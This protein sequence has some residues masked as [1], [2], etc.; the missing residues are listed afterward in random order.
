[1]KVRRID[2]SPDEWIAGCQG[3]S[4]EEEGVYVRLVARIYSRGGPLQLHNLADYCGSDPRRFWRIVNQLWQ[5]GKVQIRHDVEPTSPQDLAKI[6]GTLAIHRCEVELKSAQDRSEIGANLARKRWKN[7]NIVDA[8]PHIRARST[9]HQPSTIK[10][11]PIAPQGG[12]S[13][14]PAEEVS[15][16][17]PNP[18]AENLSEP[19]MLGKQQRNPVEPEGFSEVWAA[20]PRHVG[21]GSARTAY[22]KALRKIGPKDLLA[23]VQRYASE[24]RGQD[25]Q[26]TP[27]P[28]TWLNQERWADE[29]GYRP[30]SKMNGV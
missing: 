20:Y 1:M 17:N 2:F 30:R 5:K 12:Q 21:K 27:H 18:P 14:A 15:S 16:P 29:A 3:L 11:P 9:N 10:N 23:A 6:G 24:R 13:D 7:N 8:V 19:R 25:Q 28:A 26:F 4:E 22:R